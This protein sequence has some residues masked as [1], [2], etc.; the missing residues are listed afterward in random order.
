MNEGELYNMCYMQ[1][2]WLLK[3]SVKQYTY[4]TALMLSSF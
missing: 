2:N 4:S 3:S 1:G